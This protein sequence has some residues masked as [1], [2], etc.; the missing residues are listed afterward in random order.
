MAFPKK[1]ETK[2]NKELNR[3]IIHESDAKVAFVA[4]GALLLAWLGIGAA[5]FFFHANIAGWIHDLML[6]L[7]LGA[8]V[9][10][11]GIALATKR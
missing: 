2:M 9:I 6:V 1:E 11:S 3:K 5:S 8:G 10:A 7:V 4:L